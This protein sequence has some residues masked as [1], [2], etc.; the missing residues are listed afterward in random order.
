MDTLH[1]SFVTGGRALNSG[2]T[3]RFHDRRTPWGPFDTPLR[4]APSHGSFVTGGR[5]FDSGD[6]ARFH[7][8][9][10]PRGPFGT[11]WRTSPLHESFVTGGRAFNSGATARPFPL[12]IVVDGDFNKSTDS[13]VH[14]GVWIRNHTLHFESLHQAH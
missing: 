9:R 5:A 3:G 12:F 2:A 6:T 4:T 7:D 11:P 1:G 10:T 8:Q 13:A 14:A